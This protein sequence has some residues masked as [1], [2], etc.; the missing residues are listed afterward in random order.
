V[1]HRERDDRASSARRTMC[2]EPMAGL[3]DG[4]PDG[5]VQ[6]RA[7]SSRETDFRMSA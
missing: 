6:R 5:I 3:A 7:A 2:G 1:A 4:L